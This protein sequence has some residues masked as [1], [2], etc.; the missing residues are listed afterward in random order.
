MEED[1]GRACSE[2]AWFLRSVS[3]PLELPLYRLKLF[4]GNQGLML[5]WVHLP[6]IPDIP[7]V[8]RVVE[9]RQE[10]THT[11]RLTAPRQQ[12]SVGHDLP[13]LSDGL[14]PA[15]GQSERF[16]DQRG[17]LLVKDNNISSVLS[18]VE[19]A[20]RRAAGGQSLRR[21]Q[22]QTPLDHAADI[23]PQSLLQIGTTWH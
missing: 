22:G 4:L 18:Y 6:V 9:Y 20:Y 15:R 21:S 14:L 23:S 12:P 8:E 16:P 2:K 1:I 3:V 11:Q 10:G 5:A 7:T 13:D 17:F 19:I